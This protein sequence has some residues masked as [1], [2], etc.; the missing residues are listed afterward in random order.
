MKPMEDRIP[1]AGMQIRGK[2]EPSAV[3]PE[4]L[5]ARLEGCYVTVPTPFRDA[6][7]FPIDETALRQYVRFLLDNGLR[8]GTAT[9]LAGG[10]AGDFSTMTFEERRRVAGAVHPI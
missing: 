9:L 1:R 7:D 5:K 10:A 2:R 4:R 3:D 6:P 8:E